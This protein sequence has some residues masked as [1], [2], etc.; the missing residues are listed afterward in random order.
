MTQLKRIQKGAQLLEYNII[1]EKSI[2][3][4]LEVK[5]FLFKSSRIFPLILFFLLFLNI[6]IKN[7]FLANSPFSLMQI[8]AYQWKN[9]IATTEV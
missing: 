4:K 3:N 1:Q 5:I 2:K 7:H 8:K 9:H 6:L